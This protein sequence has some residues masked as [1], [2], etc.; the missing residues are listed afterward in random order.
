[1][2]SADDEELEPTVIA[3]AIEFLEAP[4]IV[5]CERCGCDSKEIALAVLTV[6]DTPTSGPTLYEYCPHC[7]TGLTV[8]TRRPDPES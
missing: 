4:T 3:L 6:D 8:L 2:P 1:M 5:R 7:D